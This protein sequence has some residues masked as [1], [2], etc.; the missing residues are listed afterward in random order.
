MR[1]FPD[2]WNELVDKFAPAAIAGTL[3]QVE[4]LARSKIPTLQNA[5]IVLER[6]G[7]PLLTEAH[8]ERLW[9]AFRVP[10]F[11]QIIADNGDLLATDCEAH[12]GLHIESPMLR[13]S[14]ELVD[15]S[16]CACGRKTPRLVQ[17]EH[18]GVV[19]VGQDEI[20]RR[21]SKPPHVSYQV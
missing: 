14:R 3:A 21:L 6:R 8:R 1:V 19:R 16:P 18:A 4:A 17:A 2:G 7:N 20:L 11:E 12:E 13:V 10:I 9:D 15:S 5:V